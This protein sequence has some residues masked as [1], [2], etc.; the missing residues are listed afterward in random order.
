[1]NQRSNQGA[2]IELIEGASQPLNDEEAG[3]LR[4]QFFPRGHA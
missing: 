2:L 3:E 4:N 1:M